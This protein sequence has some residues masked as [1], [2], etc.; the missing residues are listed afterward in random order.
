MAESVWPILEDA[1][2]ARW[3]DEFPNRNVPIPMLLT[4][5]EF[6]RFLLENLDVFYRIIHE[7]QKLAALFEDRDGQIKE[8]MKN[9][10]RG[11][12]FSRRF[13]GILYFDWKESEETMDAFRLALRKAR[14]AIP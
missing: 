10:F 2:Y 1:L 9:S 4:R 6:K 13:L 7:F 12:L 8:Y 3:P 14:R 11:K 5:D